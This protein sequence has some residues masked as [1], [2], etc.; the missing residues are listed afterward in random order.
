MVDAIR[1]ALKR[2]QAT[3]AKREASVA[4]LQARIAYLESLAAQLQAHI[5]DLEISVEHLRTEQRVERAAFFRMARRFAALAKSLRALGDDE[6]PTSSASS[7]SDL[8][9]DWVEG[10][11]QIDHL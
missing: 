11:D 5:A 2:K 6:E 8:I 7:T 1:S 10:Q 4:W 9:T 3:Q